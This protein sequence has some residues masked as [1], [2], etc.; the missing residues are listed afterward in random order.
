MG[1]RDFI[2]HLEEHRRKLEADLSAD[3]REEMLLEAETMV[4]MADAAV[5]ELESVIKNRRVNLPEEHAVRFAQDVF[6]YLRDQEERVKEL[7]RTA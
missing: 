6:I 1:I 4:G 3:E 2:Q 5:K 7:L